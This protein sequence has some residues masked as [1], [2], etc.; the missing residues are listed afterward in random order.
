MSIDIMTICIPFLSQD[1]LDPGHYYG[2][3]VGIAI[4]AMIGINLLWIWWLDGI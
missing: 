2:N 4:L 3:T 1:D